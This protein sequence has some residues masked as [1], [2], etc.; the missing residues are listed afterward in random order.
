MIAQTVL[1]HSLNKRRAFEHAGD[2][3]FYLTISK[4]NRL[5]SLISPVRFPSPLTTATIALLFCCAL[6]LIIGPSLFEP[7]GTLLAYALE[8]RALR[9][10]VAVTVGA[11][12]AASGVL[13]QTLVRNDLA[14]PD[15]VGA[16]SGASLALITGAF[17]SRVLNIPVGLDSALASRLLVAT[18]GAIIALLIVA[19]LAGKRS[20]GKKGLANLIPASLD[21]ATLILGGVMVSIIASAVIA[22]VDHLMQAAGQVRAADLGGLL[23]GT[24]R[25]DIGWFTAAASLLLTVAV[26]SSW[27]GKARQLDAMLLDDDQAS[28]AGV[29]VAMLRAM[30][31][32]SCGTLAAVAVVLAGPIAFIGLL[33]PHA[34]RMLLAGAARTAVATPAA[35]FSPGARGTFSNPDIARALHGKLLVLAAILGATLMVLADAAART[36]NLGTGRLPTGVLTSLVGGALFIALLRRRM[37]RGA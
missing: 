27:A 23:L 30:L 32:L 19:G 35:L 22:L 36:L 16:S 37:A 17:V 5:A 33:G 15:L 2:P 25:D 10:I 20:P 24:I 3:P 28:S 31:F 1:Y 11:A 14:S 21:P 12:L 6:R 8:I 4:F 13:L 7:S 34:A 9:V 26:I 18:T 29:R